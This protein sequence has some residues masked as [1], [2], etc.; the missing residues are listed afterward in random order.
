M[1]KFR[2]WVAL[3]SVPVLTLLGCGG[4]GVSNNSQ[5]PPDTFSVGPNEG[6]DKTYG[7]ITIHI[8]A[9]GTFPN[10]ST[11]SLYQSAQAPEMPPEQNFVLGKPA[12]KLTSTAIPQKDITVS[13]LDEG[14]DYI[15]AI[16]SGE[17]WQP[18]N[19]VK[20][21]GKTSFFLPAALGRVANRGGGKVWD[22]VIGLVKDD[23][24]DTE[25]AIKRLEDGTDFGDPGTILCI[26]G[27]MDNYQS[28]AR[29][30]SRARARFGGSNVFSYAF[31]WKEGAQEAGIQLA[32]L[33]APY[34]N[35]I[36]N[37][38]FVGYSQGVLVA[39]HALERLGATATVVDLVSIMGPNE[40]SHWAD[41]AD[42]AFNIIK[43]W[44]N[45]TFSCSPFGVTVD[46]PAIRE[47]RP[48]SA[49]LTDLNKYHNTQRGDVNYWLFNGNKDWVVTQDS[50]WA[51]HVPLEQ[52]TGG[53]VWRHTVSG[54]THFNIKSNTGLIDQ[55]FGSMGL[56]FGNELSILIDPAPNDVNAITDGWHFSLRVRNN[57]KS[58]I[59]I[60][61]LAFETYL[62]DGLTYATQ[63]YKPNDL[64]LGD[65]YP[66]S[67]QVWPVTLG[68][69][70]TSEVIYLY[71]WPDWEINRMEDLLDDNKK[72]RT[73]KVI[74]TGTLNGRPVKTEVFVTLR[75]N[76][77]WPSLA[78]TRGEPQKDD[79]V[80]TVSADRPPR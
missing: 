39:R 58:T 67:Y 53:T 60:K 65:P 2:K 32:A 71:A 37:V 59:K 24:P 69:G 12:L 21:G 43:L 6:T 26:H 27:V 8:E 15:A 16:K 56:K 18:L 29:I 77:Y 4:G 5:Q 50:A 36:K 57:S 33:L 23:L 75:W 64:F 19:R 54:A 38:I 79:R 66:C 47:L 73:E 25:F 22:W 9:D 42:F 76:D 68:P 28:M 46:D 62:K 17:D 80:G 35:R 44:L 13:I 14:K 7:D 49:F 40:G 10:G 74:L 30:G 11:L 34:K 63:W 31:P 45:G 1:M 70:K 3:L 52:L 20:A 55:M 72:A 78:Q 41:E 51:G 48:G 61:D